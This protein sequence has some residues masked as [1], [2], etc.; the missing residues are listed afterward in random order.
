MCRSSSCPGPGCRC[1]R[2][3]V[4]SGAAS[5]RARGSRAGRG[6]GCLAGGGNP[7]EQLFISYD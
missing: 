6:E 2:G 1:R 4:G 5:G 3:A 7:G